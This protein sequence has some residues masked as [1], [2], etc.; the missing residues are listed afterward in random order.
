MSGFEGSKYPE[1]EQLLE[2][3]LEEQKLLVSG[4]K[5]DSR[6]D[7]ELW[8]E[9]RMPNQVAISLSGEPLLYPL[10]GEF[11]ALC[12]KRGMTTFLVTNGS[13]PKALENLSAMPTQ[14]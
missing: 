7:Q 3:C 10:L 9:A 13:V 2:K 1:P 11:I 12:K 8:D 14:L 6:C 5:G 4:F